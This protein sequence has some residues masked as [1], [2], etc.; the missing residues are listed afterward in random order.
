MASP[1]SP[2]KNGEKVSVEAVAKLLRNGSSHE[3]ERPD[4]AQAAEHLLSLDLIKV[5]VN[6]YVRC[7]NHKDR[8]YQYLRDRSCRGRIRV[9]DDLDEDR[10]DFH[11]P[12][13]GRTVYLQR[14]SRLKMMQVAVTPEKVAS[15]LEG[16]LAKSGLQQKQIYP[17]VWRVDMPR[18]EAKL[19][20]ADYCNVDFI[21]RD[22]AVNN[23]VCYVVVDSASCKQR[24]LPETWLAWSR[25]ADIVCQ[26]EMLSNLLS[27]AAATIPSSEV[28]VSVPVYS[29]TVRPIVMGASSG[30][31]EVAEEKKPE[32]KRTW[33]DPQTHTTAKC[34]TKKDGTFCLSTKTQGCYDGEVEFP[35]RNGAPTK[36]M[37]LMKVL[38]F[39]HPR[40]MNLATLIDQIYPERNNVRK[41]AKALADL[42]KNIRTL[43][44][45]IR[46]KKL[47]PSGINPEVLPA[48]DFE[49]TEKTTICLRLACVHNMDVAGCDA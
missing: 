44:S 31:D 14:K 3:M 29:T 17:W 6:E 25:L 46:N 27:S 38:C 10:G 19:I 8:D 34:W 42:L 12:E 1:F 21:S 39:T 43:I 47:V 15:F 20:V 35:M 4:I 18:G 36:Q 48:R 41:E 2:Q 23:R 37:Q 26:P 33:P 32:S 24:F 49:V 11:C 22:W 7:V 9:D 5:E 45:D 13:C 30:R 40:E 28:R 16:I